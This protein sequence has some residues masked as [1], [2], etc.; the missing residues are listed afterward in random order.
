V[1]V[2]MIRRYMTS[3]DGICQAIRIPDVSQLERKRKLETQLRAE[4][5]SE[6][7][8]ESDPGRDG[9]DKNSESLN[10]LHDLDGLTAR[11]RTFYAKFESNRWT[12][13]RYTSI[14]TGSLPA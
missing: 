2:I 3:Y 11:A 5:D 8:S 4:P 13:T 10:T 12:W 6:S 14:S 1:T 7:D 9:Q